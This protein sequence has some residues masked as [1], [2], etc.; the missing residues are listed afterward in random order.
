MLRSAFTGATPRM[1]VIRKQQLRVSRGDMNC[2]DRNYCAMDIVRCE[3]TQNTI[4]NTPGRDV[5]DGA[6]KGGAMRGKEVSNPACASDFY[7]TVSAIISES[8]S[9]PEDLVGKSWRRSWQYPA[10]RA[11]LPPSIAY[12]SQ[13]R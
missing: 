3:P 7:G 10:P 2:P 12:Q 6:S 13:P 1:A 8:A 9:S 4:V 5:E 11:A